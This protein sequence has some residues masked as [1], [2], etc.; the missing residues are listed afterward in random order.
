MPWPRLVFHPC[1]GTRQRPAA[2][3]GHGDERDALAKTKG[4]KGKRAN[5]D[6]ASAG[7]IEKG[8]RQRR[9]HAGAD[10]EGGG[11]AEQGGGGQ[12]R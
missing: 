10:E 3:R 9:G 8:A 6:I 5:C 1:A 4:E 7:D 11:K 2:N 12:K